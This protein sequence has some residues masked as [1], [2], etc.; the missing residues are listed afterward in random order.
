[1]SHLRDHSKLLGFHEPS[2]ICVM[3]A[4][5]HTWEFLGLIEKICLTL[6]CSANVGV[7]FAEPPKH[8]SQHW[9]PSL[10]H[11]PQLIH[12][13]TVHSLLFENQP[14]I[15]PCLTSLPDPL[16]R[17]CH[18]LCYGFNSLTA[19]VLALL[20]PVVKT[21][22]LLTSVRPHYLSFRTPLWLYS[23]VESQVLPITVFMTCPA[24]TSP[25]F[26]PALLPPCSLSNHTDPSASPQGTDTCFSPR[27]LEGRV[28]PPTL[29][30][31]ASEKPPCLLWTPLS[32]SSPASLYLSSH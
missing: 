21:A 22:A 8:Q 11:T 14:S 15:Q 2:F 23:S 32:H 1:M 24:P 19:S 7:L 28:L 13:Q 4:N 20:Q 3:R 27:K 12:Q 25:C 26:P 16:K 29:S 17:S 6:R 9:L 10:S 5:A 31:S 30:V 18:P